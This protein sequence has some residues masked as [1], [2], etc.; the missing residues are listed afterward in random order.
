MAQ[1]SGAV[2][3]EKVSKSYG[4]LKV[5]KEID[6]VAEP[7]TVTCVI[8]PSGCGK[9][10]MLRCINHLTPVDSG[11][12]WVNGELAGYRE[13]NGRL[14]DAPD[15]E[16]NR[17]RSQIGMVFQHFNLYGHMTVLRNITEAPVKVLKQSP[18]EAKQRALELLEQVGLSDKAASY[19]RKLSGGQQ[20]RVAIVRALAGSPSL[21]LFDEPTSALDPELVQEVLDVM[22]AIA[23]QGLT[24]IVV[25][26][27]LQFAREVAD[28]V[29]FMDAGRIVEQG[30]PAEVLDNPRE[31]RTRKFIAQVR[32]EQPS[33]IPALEH[34]LSIEV[35]TL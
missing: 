27:E 5:L 32:R 18:K 13:H 22:L 1:V 12:I 29:V 3:L 33:E 10:T 15:Q 7:G 4:N 28:Q 21:V 11:W 25:T 34:S 35:P 31:A 9:S 24:M 8:G 20:Q 14:I 2:R 16:I 17:M 30:T 6:F 23:R 19:P 26:H